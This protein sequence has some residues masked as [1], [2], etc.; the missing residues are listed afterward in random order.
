MMITT[1][2]IIITITTMISIII[3]GII[4]NS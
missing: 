2:K 4:E 1:I 3:M